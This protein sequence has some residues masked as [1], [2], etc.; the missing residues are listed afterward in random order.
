LK[1]GAGRKREALALLSIIE[2]CG[3]CLG[4]K[5]SRVGDGNQ[6]S[7]LGAVEVLLLLR[8]LDMVWI[9]S[10]WGRIVRVRG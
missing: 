7:R 3:S 5:R 6:W 2:L 10:G 8:E 9:G 1:L 4:N